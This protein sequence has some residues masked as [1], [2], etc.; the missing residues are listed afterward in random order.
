[1]TNIWDFFKDFFKEAEESS[2][3]KPIFNEILARS[4]EE[5]AA[6]ENWKG[7]LPCRRF[8]DLLAAQ[9]TIYQSNPAGVDP[10]LTFLQ[11]DSTKGFALH[12]DRLDFN[13]Q[14]TSHFLDLLKE[15]ILALPYQSQLSNVRTW[16]E[17]DWVQTVERHYL[18]PKKSWEEGKLIDQLFGNV[19][20]E[21]T[22]RND[23]PRLLTFRA[24]AYA[25][26]LYAPPRDFHELMQ[27][28]LA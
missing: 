20:I 11:S 24:T 4:E 17:K 9:Y 5:K 21:L 27:A 2:P 1:M 15:K 7:S 14:D 16:T 13:Q 25:D 10:A 19:T 22:L 8:F 18:K 23:Q 3:S 26:R 28:I 12:F 6:Y